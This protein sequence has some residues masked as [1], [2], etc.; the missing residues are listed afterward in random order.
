MHPREYE[1]FKQANGST[2]KNG[3]ARLAIDREG[4]RVRACQGPH[5]S[6]D[7]QAMLNSTQ[8]RALVGG[9][10]TMAIWRWQRD[11]RVQF[12]LPDVVINHRNYWYA[13]SIRRWQASHAATAVA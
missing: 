5:P 4:G 3:D 1:R 9:V 6:P 7:D 8:V 11:P 12:P 10:T 2:P 13:G